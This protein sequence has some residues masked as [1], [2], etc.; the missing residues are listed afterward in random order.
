MRYT[1]GRVV[2]QVVAILAVGC[3]NAGAAGVSVVWLAAD[4]ELRQDRRL[5]YSP[6]V[7]CHRQGHDEPCSIEQLW[8][9]LAG[10]VGY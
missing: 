7:L 9:H 8:R 4:R 10:I 2:L 6:P 5:S 3:R 1:I